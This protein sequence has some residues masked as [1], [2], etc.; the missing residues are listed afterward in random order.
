MATDCSS[1]HCLGIIGP[2]T[3]IFPPL[4]QNHLLC[5]YERRRLA[6]YVPLSA[7]H[8]IGTAVMTD[9]ATVVSQKKRN[10]FIYLL[11]CLKRAMKT[12]Y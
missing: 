4:S 7:Q 12:T 6:T 2:I 8:K 3:S 5:H 10:H 11:E 1:N 9:D